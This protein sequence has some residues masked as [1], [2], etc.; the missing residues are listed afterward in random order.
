[1][2]LTLAFAI[3]HNII[4]L[5]Y[6][7][8][9][10]TLKRFSLSLILSSCVS[11]TIYFLCMISGFLA[12]SGILMSNLLKNYCVNDPLIL[13]T[14][15]ILTV[16]LLGTYP[17]QVFSARDAIFEILKDYICVKKWIR[18]SVTFGLVFVFM[19]ISALC[20][21]MGAVIELGGTLTAAPLSFHAC[22]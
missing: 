7:L 1:M 14:R 13:A 16:T 3:H 22:T 17:F 11:A 8:D 15:I 9:N 21:S 20:P 18:Y 6:S 19:L 5:Y 4:S 10:N 12:F 2:K